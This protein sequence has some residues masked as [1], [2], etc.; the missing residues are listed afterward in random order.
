MCWLRAHTWRE[1]GI[2]ISLRLPTLRLAT[3]AP[4]TI[5]IC[6]QHCLPRLGDLICCKGMNGLSRC[7]GFNVISGFS[8]CKGFNDISGFYSCISGCNGCF[9]WRF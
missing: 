4:M 3:A 6:R 8:R 2:A 7:K 1:L 9:G 5:P